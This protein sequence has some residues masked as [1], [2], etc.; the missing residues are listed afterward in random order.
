MVAASVIGFTLFVGDEVLE[1]IPTALI[2]GILIFAGLGMLE[3]GLAKNRKILPWA[4]F[5][6]VVMIFAVIV[7]FG[8]IEGV[9]AGMLATLVFFTVR[10]RPHRPD[11][12]QVHG[13]RTAKQQGRA[14]Y[15]IGQF[16]WR[17][18]GGAGTS[19]SCA[20]TFLRQRDPLISRLRK[21]V[22]G[23]SRPI[24]LMLDF[25]AVSGFDFS[26]VNALSRF[27]WA[28][29]GVGTK[30]VLSAVSG[31]LRSS[32]RRSL[33]EAAFS[34]L[35]LEPDTDRALECC[36][37][38]VIA[39]W[40]AGVTTADDQRA[41]LLEHVGRN[42]ERHL[43]EQIE[44][45]DLMNELRDWL[46]PCEYAAEETLVGADG[47]QVRLQFLISGR[48]SARDGDG[49][50]LHQFGPGDAIGQADAF[51]TQAASVVADEACRT[52]AMTSAARHRLEA[53]EE[54]LAFKLYRFLLAR[55]FGLEQQDGIPADEPGS[56]DNVAHGNE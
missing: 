46:T 7:L 17:K 26:A 40:R 32:L 31:Q 13:A 21:S 44:F 50:R 8:L 33:P 3:E 12:I 37:D 36:E 18:A 9:G 43:E 49:S 25:T 29:N 35:T 20:A 14:T 11:R 52:M 56:R 24:C 6:I 51:G 47:P 1:F 34:E 38:I 16:C 15:L 28:A 54:R 22:E 27:L 10:L 48:A 23:P 53:D 2:G 39:A 4:E 5:A 42:L 19:I 55:Q 30:V 41:A 45:E